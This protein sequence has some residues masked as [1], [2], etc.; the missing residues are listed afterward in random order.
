[1]ARKKKLVAKAVKKDNTISMVILGVVAVLAIVGLVLLF[2]AAQSSGMFAAVAP[3]IYGGA[4]RGLGSMVHQD[5]RAIP[6][7]ICPEGTTECHT[8]YL[9]TGTRRGIQDVAYDHLPSW[10]AYRFDTERGRNYGYLR[11]CGDDSMLI[12]Y[13]EAGYYMGSRSNL[14]CQGEIRKDRAGVCCYMEEDTIKAGP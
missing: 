6:A 11:K 3:R 1:M 8:E 13:P 2:S 5:T 12:S 4:T 10:Q 9:Y 14:I 7:T